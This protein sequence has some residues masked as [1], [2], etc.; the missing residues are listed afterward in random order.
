[1]TNER[2]TAKGII[3]NGVRLSPALAHRPSLSPHAPPN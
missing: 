1:M 3:R 2:M